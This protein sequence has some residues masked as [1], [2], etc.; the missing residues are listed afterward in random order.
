V[1]ELPSPFPFTSRY[2]EIEIARLDLAEGREVPYLKRRFLPLP[3]RFQVLHEKLVTEGDRLDNIAAQELGDPEQF[4]FLCDANNAMDPLELEAVGRTLL[5][6]LPE[7]LPGT[8]G[9]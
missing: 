3:E 5:V 8:T 4:W 6:T 2:H 1:T 9:V 7:G